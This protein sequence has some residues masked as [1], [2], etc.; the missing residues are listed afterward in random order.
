MEPT[1]VRSRRRRTRSRGDSRNGV[2]KWLLSLQHN[3]RRV[4]KWCVIAFLVLF[5][6]FRALLFWLGT[7]GYSDVGLGDERE[8][9]LYSLGPPIRTLDSGGGVD[10]ATPETQSGG[11]TWAYT[12]GSGGNIAVLFDYAGR[13]A[14]IRCGHP[15]IQ[16]RACPSM[17]GNDIGMT[18][19]DLFRTFGAPDR[20]QIAQGN[21]TA[22]Y[23]DVGVTYRLRQFHVYEME[24][25]AKQGGPF[26]KLY[27][28]LRMLVP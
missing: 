13:T 5:M 27:R 26:G 4:L 3:Y 15:D 23:D 9:V 6:L 14:A 18:E 24:L 7:L 16:P 2:N 1:Q 28:F 12:T 8:A 21:K 11:G 19:G 17:F 10:P 20:E 22:I 25:R